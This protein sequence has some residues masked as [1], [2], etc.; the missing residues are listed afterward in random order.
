MACIDPLLTSKAPYVALGSMTEAST[1]DQ[2]Q[3]GCQ[4]FQVPS[5]TNTSTVKLFQKSVIQLPAAITSSSPFLQA[6]TS[7]AR[8]HE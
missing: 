8:H 7:F 1:V 5:M 4:R 3:A 6:V 2:F